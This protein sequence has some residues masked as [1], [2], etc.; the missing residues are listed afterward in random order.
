MTTNCRVGK[1]VFND[2]V[3]QEAQRHTVSLTHFNSERTLAYLLSLRANILQRGT[4]LQPAEIECKKLLKSSILCG[5]LQVLQPTNP[6]DEEKG[7]ARSS[8]ST[9][10]S[11]PTD[12]TSNQI[13]IAE[14]PK[15]RSIWPSL[16]SI[17]GSQM[18][19]LIF[20]YSKLFH[21]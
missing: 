6:F 13:P 12:N 3:E 16:V 19:I 8:G 17:T 21:S 11:T 9:A 14:A 1:Y 18:E 20:Y 7:E 2:A 5:G 10:G 4:A 15:I